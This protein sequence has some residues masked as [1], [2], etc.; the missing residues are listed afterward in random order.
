[1]AEIPK[2]WYE[3]FLTPQAVFWIFAAFVWAVIFW[4]DSKDNWAKI[5]ELQTTVNK[6]WQIQSSQNEKTNQRLEEALDWIEF[7]KGRQ[8]GYKEALDNLKNK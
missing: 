7:E 8:N 4:K 1:M 2:R 5:D 3:S 6:Q